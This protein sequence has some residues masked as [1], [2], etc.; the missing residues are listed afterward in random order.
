[1]IH[2][3]STWHMLILHQLDNK[4]YTLNIR[5]FVYNEGCFHSKNE[6]GL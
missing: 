3:T 1:M 5:Y 6:H 4:S 2:F